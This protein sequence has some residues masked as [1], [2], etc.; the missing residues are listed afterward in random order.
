MHYDDFL[1]FFHLARNLFYVENVKTK[2]LR[3]K[4]ILKFLLPNEKMLYIFF[5]FLF[6]FRSQKKIKGVSIALIKMDFNFKLQM[7]NCIF[8]QQCISKI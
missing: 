6:A 1:I 3:I 2:N 8:A 7:F 4:K 5:M